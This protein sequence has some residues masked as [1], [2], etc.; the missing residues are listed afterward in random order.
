MLVKICGIKSREVLHK[1]RECGADVAGFVFA[2]GWRQLT[3]EQAAGIC[4]GVCGIKKAGV[5]VNAPLEEIACA[6]RE[7]GLDYVQLHGDETAEFAAVLRKEFHVKIIRA[8]RYRESFQAEAAVSFPADVLLVD[9]Y[10]KASYGGTG[11]SFDWRAAKAELGRIDK[12]LWIA[13]G[14]NRENV[15]SMLELL[16]PNGIDVSSGVEEN[17]EKSLREIERFME[18]AR[19]FERRLRL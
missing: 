4:C 7:C 9:T 8:F 16:R 17:G 19:A 13:G 2:K 15:G 3:V 10:Q 6:V 1:V 14:I 18:C 5:F 11:Q 12:P